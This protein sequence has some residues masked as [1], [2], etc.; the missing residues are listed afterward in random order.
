M[1]IIGMVVLFR[2]LNEFETL[3]TD[4]YLDFED[5]EALAAKINVGNILLA[6]VNLVPLIFQIIGYITL[7]NWAL[8]LERPA[9]YESQYGESGISLVL[10]ELSKNTKRT[11]IGVVLIILGEVVDMI[12]LN[13]F[14][15]VGVILSLVGYI[16]FGTGLYRAGKFLEEGPT[17]VAPRFHQ[18]INLQSSNIEMKYCE[19]CGAVNSN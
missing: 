14:N 17:S 12:P 2:I 7:N 11:V 9:D 4:P 3:I 10:G 5:V 1:L 6:L 19:K 15:I 18:T 16:M 13:F 8:D